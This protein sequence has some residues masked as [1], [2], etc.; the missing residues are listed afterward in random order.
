METTLI[1]SHSYTIN[2][3]N[4]VYFRP[5]YGYEG[6]GQTGTN[7]T[8]TN[9]NVITIT[10]PYDIVIEQLGKRMPTHHLIKL[11]Y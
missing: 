1:Q 6:N 4:V 10:C 11:D 7:F 9:G 3:S 5:R 8:M 2:L